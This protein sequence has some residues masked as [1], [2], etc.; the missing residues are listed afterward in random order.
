MSN[1][2]MPVT[3]ETGKKETEVPP[4][5]GLAELFNNAPLYA[6]YQFAS[7]N[8]LK[9]VYSGGGDSTIPL[10]FDG[11]C[12]FCN[13]TTTFTLDRAYIVSGTNWESARITKRYSY[14][15]CD[16]TC[17]RSDSHVVHF[18]LRLHTMKVQK[19]GQYPSLADIAN[20]ESKKFKKVLSKSDASEFHMAIGLAAHGVGIGSFVYLRRIFERLITKRFNQFGDANSWNEDGF[21]RLRMVEKIEFLRE[22]LPPFLVEHR[23]IYS[24]LSSGMHE[25]DEGKCL[26]FFDVMKNSIIIILEEDKLKAEELARRKQFSEAIKKF[27]PDEN[28]SQSAAE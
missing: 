19:V 16:I 27:S 10:R 22:Y 6:Q 5:S 20:D 13:K 14:D 18:W 8:E 28:N 4:F 21:N 2:S 3:S 25:L 15:T 17:A 1:I 23:K 26:A 9:S 7:M 24:I 11:H 12:P